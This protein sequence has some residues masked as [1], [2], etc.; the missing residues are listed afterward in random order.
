MGRQPQDEN[1][2][3]QAKER[4]RISIKVKRDVVLLCS[5]LWENGINSLP[6]G[7]LGTSRE[8]VPSAHDKHTAFKG[9]TLEEEEHLVGP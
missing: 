3:P 8:R 1:G 2:A 4:S 7:S 9:P 6:G 5:H